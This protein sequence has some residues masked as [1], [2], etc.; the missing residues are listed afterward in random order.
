MKWIANKEE[1]DFKKNGLKPREGPNLYTELRKTSDDHESACVSLHMIMIS[2]SLYMRYDITT[3][4]FIEFRK[5]YTARFL[6]CTLFKKPILFLNSMF[7][8]ILRT[9][10]KAKNLRTQ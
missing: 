9:L 4:V 8:I 5:N 2:L 7:F 10:I 6:C 1:E 3:N